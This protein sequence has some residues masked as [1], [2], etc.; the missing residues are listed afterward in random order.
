MNQNSFSN[1]LIEALP[2]IEK[3]Q[4]KTFVIKIGGSILECE[5]VKK[6]LIR[7]L[8]LLYHLG[9]KLIIVHG[10]GKEITSRL[11]LMGMKSTFVMGHRVTDKSQIQEVEMVLSGKINKELTLLLNNAG[12]CSIGINGKDGGF[13]KGSKKTI[14]SDKKEYNLGNVGEITH[15]DTEFLSK[16]V[17]MDMIPI[18]SPIAYDEKHETLNINADTLAAAIAGAM[19]AEKLILQSD[20]DGI[21]KDFE[22]KNS[23]ISI[24]SLE[25]ADHLLS[26]DSISSG[27]IPKLSCC[28][29]AVRKGVKSSHII[30]GNT[31]HSLLL[32][33]FSDHGIGTMIQGDNYE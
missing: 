3:F 30:N 16:I 32:E 22:D 5:S 26:S 23:L 14:I 31:K 1:T 8:S 18:I 2:Y 9:F 24:L 29:E 28:I 25:S 17:A 6:D 27:M 4:G 33:L 20:I 19:K 10:G 15:I 7:D 13:I 21:Y 11:K 12:V